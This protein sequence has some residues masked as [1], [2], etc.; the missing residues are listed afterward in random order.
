MNI[1]F[2]YLACLKATGNMSH[3][4]Q[5]HMPYNSTALNIFNCQVV[6]V[7]YIQRQSDI[8][9]LNILRKLSYIINDYPLLDNFFNIHKNYT[10]Y[11]IREYISSI[12]ILS[13][14]LRRLHMT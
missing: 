13:K 3:S 6:A 4:P 11:I 14:T 8:V 2:E 1:K 10:N 5:Y 7:E 12:P 9:V